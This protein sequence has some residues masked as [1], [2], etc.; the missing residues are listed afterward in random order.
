MTTRIALIP[1]VQTDLYYLWYY[2]FDVVPD[3]VNCGTYSSGED[4][5]EKL[6]GAAPDVVVIDVYSP[7]MED[8]ELMNRIKL[9]LPKVK[10]IFRSA[11]CDEKV[12]VSVIN[13]GVH[14]FIYRAG[15]EKE[16]VDCIRQVM[17]G[18]SGLCSVS[19]TLL[20]EAT[21]AQRKKD[22]RL[23]FGLTVREAEIVSYLAD[24]LSYKQIAWVLKISV[25]TVRK[26]CANLYIKLDV[27]NKV[28]AINKVHNYVYS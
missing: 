3:I 20:Y 15:E 25:E 9:L 28:Q 6:K 22:F 2:F 18:Q 16:L 7:G 8:F 12:I 13:K 14:G 10:I 1:L 27:D 11:E 4:A 19:A 17:A 23:H 24:G 26:H 21:G 5:L